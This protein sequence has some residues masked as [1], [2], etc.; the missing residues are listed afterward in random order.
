MSNDKIF[1]MSSKAL[2]TEAKNS[3]KGEHRKI[4]LNCKVTIKKNRPISIEI[5]SGNNL[6]LYKNLHL[7]YEIDESPIEAKSRPLSKEDVIKQ[8]SKT[9]SSMY[10]FKNINVDLDDNCFLPK[11]SSLNELRRVALEQV[12]NF[13][14]SKCAR[15]LPKIS[16]NAN[17]C[18]I[19]K[20]VLHLMRKKRQ[21]KHCSNK[22]KHSQSLCFIKRA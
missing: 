19:N 20:K 6:L 15:R 11:I 2:S 10:E 5:S 9:T 8:I 22:C 4:A 1:K 13:A 16:I 7:R 12:E 3:Y 17:K 14:I 18:T 21:L